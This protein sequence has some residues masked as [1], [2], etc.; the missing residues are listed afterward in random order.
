M[1][2]RPL[3]V[4]VAALAAVTLAAPAARAQA[5]DVPSFNTPYGEDGYGLYLLFQ[6]D[7]NDPGG[8]LTWRRSGPDF[9]IGFRGGAISSSWA[10]PPGQSS[11]GLFGGIDVKNEWI[12]ADEQFPLD[13]AWVT[14][15]GLGWVPDHDV[16]L[17]RI[18]FGFSLGRSL[19]EPNTTI[20]PYV[21][22]R[23]LL[24]AAFQ[25]G[26]NHLDGNFDL[27]LGVDVMLQQRWKLRFAATVGQDD[28][29]GFGVAF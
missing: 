7:V 11:L 22:P 26:P 25:D 18:P 23:V 9:D 20:T 1:K 13:V 24:D 19:V 27:D 28:A 14:G 10:S 12:H 15:A 8:M 17:F 2:K 5:W 4:V 29:L 16:A 3:F 21:Y 6:N